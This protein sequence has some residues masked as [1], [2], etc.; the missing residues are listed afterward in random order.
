MPGR[1]RRA[2]LR[3]LP[4]QEREFISVALREETVGGTLVLL[5]AA[6]A[7]VWASSPLGDTYATVQ[8]TV[9]G[10]PV[11]HLDLTLQQWS[12]DG[13]LAVFFFVAGLE[14]K[15]E[16]VV[17]QLRNAAE[18]VLPVVA[19]VCGMVAPALVYLA[20]T[21]GHPSARPGWAV[22]MATDIAFALAVLAIA[23]QGGRTRL[24]LLTLAIADDIGA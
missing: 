20:V 2:V 4:T 23:G 12:A 3:A 19:A 24:F 11:L 21:S 9:V 6:L 16:L 1:A 17:G 10:P 5:A 8:D 13:L 14:L 15:R 7:V 22:P 18:A